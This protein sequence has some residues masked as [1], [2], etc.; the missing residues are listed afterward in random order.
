MHT[1]QHNSNI[2]SY[3]Q[4]RNNYTIHYILVLN[5]VLY[6]VE[7]IVDLI[8]IILNKLQREMGGVGSQP[9]VTIMLHKRP[10]HYETQT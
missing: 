7:S 2:F 3:R 10:H 9:G 5:V 1:L 4:T 8:V 6:N